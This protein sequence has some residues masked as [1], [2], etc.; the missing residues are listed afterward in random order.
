[1]KTNLFPRATPITALLWFTLSATL[2]AAQPVTPLK[3]MSFNIWVQG[4]LSLSNCIEVIRS[5][6]A[7]IVGLQECN[8]STAQTIATRLGFSVQPDGDSS[9]VSRYPIVASIPTTGGRGVTIQ[10]APGQRVHFFNCHLAAYPYG[11]YDLKAGRSQSFILDQ[12]NQ[13]RMPALTNLLAAMK[14]YL[15]TAEPCFLTGDFNAPSHLDYTNFPWPTSIACTNAGLRDSYAETHPNNRKYPGA[16]AYNEPGITWTPKTDQEPNGVF[17][18]ID[19][20]HY[21]QG[22]GVSVTAAMEIDQRNSINPWPSDHRA[23]LTTFTLTPPQARDKASAPVPPDQ[24]SGVDLN[25]TLSWLPGS[26][27]AS[28]TIYFGT[29]SPGILLSNTSAASL[30]LTNLLASTTYFWRIDTLTPNGSIPGDIWSFTTKSTNVVLYEWD[31]AHADL[32]P[33][34]GNGV[35]A[36]ADGQAT[37]TLTL[38]GT[39]DGAIVPHIEGKPTQYLRAPGFTAPGH[40][41]QVTFTDTSPNGGGA[42]INQY[43][44]IFDVL[45]PGSVGWVPFFN[46]NPANANDA[47]FYVNAAGALG[48]T[49]L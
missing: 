29:N 48:I 8:G 13:T 35:L 45:L 44:L 15:A 40:G 9:I 4:G 24:A 34:L 25:P 7:D 26:N 6:G 38:F 31:F 19:F 46:T 49:A 11:P 30:P 5:S 36:Y 32:S 47:D 20:V 21:S 33:T 41:Y 22:D 17:D 14:P 37:A 12:E 28:Q 2:P 16:F 27:A 39:T 42:Y 23:V 1:M 18:R 3:V 43:T 10:L